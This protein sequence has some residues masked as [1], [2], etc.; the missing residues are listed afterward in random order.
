MPRHKL[1]KFDRQKSSRN[2]GKLK[3]DNPNHP[4]Y[5][6]CIWALNFSITVLKID[7]DTAY[8]TFYPQLYHDDFDMPWKR[9]IY[10]LQQ[11]SLSQKDKLDL[12]RTESLKLFERHNRAGAT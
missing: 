2:A 12:I 3:T 7:H 5:Y 6:Y 11:L 9:M 8:Y 10:R 4:L 1:T